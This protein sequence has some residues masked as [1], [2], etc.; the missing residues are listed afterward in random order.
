MATD[1]SQLIAGL[2]AGTG[3]GRTPG[4][5][6][7]QNA[8]ITGAQQQNQIGAMQI[9]A[10]KQQQAQEQADQQR[11]NAFTADYG[12]NPT[13]DKLV[14]AMVQFPKQYQAL[15][16]AHDAKDA[17][18][19]TADLG[20]WSGVHSAVSSGKY[21]I[22]ATAIENRIKAE[23]AANPAADTTAE[24][25]YLTGL[26]AGDPDT[27]KTLKAQSL[28]DI[29]IA[30]GKDK[31][32]ENYKALGGGA[33]GAVKG[34]VVGRAIGRYGDDGQFHVDYRDPDAEANAL[35]VPVFDAD[36]HRIGTRLISNGGKGGD[37]ASSGQ[38]ASGGGAG[39]Y[40]GGWTPRARNGGDNPDNA[41]DGK[42]SGAARFLGVDPSADIST[43]SPLKIA[44]AMTLSEGGSGSLADRNNNPA[45]L[46]NGD[47]TY[48]KFPTKEAGLNAAAALVARKLK[49]GQ[50]TVQSL[51]EGLPAGGAKGDPSYIGPVGG[52]A[53]AAQIR[54]GDISSVPQQMRAAVQ[55]IADGRSAPPRPG[56]RNGEALLDAV[57]AYDPTFDVAN[58]TSRTKTR[59]DFTSGA[60]AK[61]I[62]AMN[63]AMGHLMHLDDQ[64]HDL[65]NF[66][67]MPG[68]LNPIYNTMRSAAGNTALPAFNQTKQAA[69]SE[70]R[71]VFAG[72][73][74]GNL[75]ELEAFEANLD[76]SKSPE[77]LHAVIK[78][79]VDLLSS[80]LTALRDQYAQGMGRSDQVPTFIKPSIVRS[81]KQRFGIDLGDGATR[82]ASAAPATPPVAGG[83]RILRVRPK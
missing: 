6:S 81:A 60:S 76:S 68:L 33:E 80:R 65:G 62:T 27:I 28:A 54:P 2:L 19:Q 40:T 39:R 50:T 78:N 51:I 4:D 5:V 29:A 70:L 24:E 59:S 75:H 56:T 67:T 61:S 63:T 17:A 7:L 57:T 44:Q 71:K 46:R 52:S 36:G 20:Y 64:A 30:L 45:N 9:D 12:A 22:A 73:G 32:A 13:P 69:A 1:P 47:G 8:Q 66:S 15:K 37:P 74:G 35:E 14:N 77:Q 3:F 49:N 11:F 26:R 43:I 23:K 16:A 41:V 42:I 55:A 82:Q 10:Y 53:A 34:Q 72:A 21:D 31:F 18:A 79:A 48:K 38:P 83:F 25:N 58:A